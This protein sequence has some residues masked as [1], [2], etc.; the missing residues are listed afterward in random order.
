[1]KQ[2][3]Q[4]QTGVVEMETRAR[5]KRMRKVVTNV[6]AFQSGKDTHIE[7]GRRKKQYK[8]TWFNVEKKNSVFF[9]LT[10]FLLVFFSSCIGVFSGE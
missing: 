5:S 4:W 6:Y 9:G 2:L 1:M 3:N 8:S 7:I 10:A